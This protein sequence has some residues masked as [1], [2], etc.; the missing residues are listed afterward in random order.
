LLRVTFVR[1]TDPGLGARAAELVAI[2]V[3]IYNDF[4]VND[5]GKVIGHDPDRSTRSDI[6]RQGNPTDQSGGG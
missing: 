5:G 1:G 3:A 2:Y 4:D 6:K